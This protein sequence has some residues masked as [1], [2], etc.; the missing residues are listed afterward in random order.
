MLTLEQRGL[1]LTA[2]FAHASS[3]EL[4]EMDAATKMAYAFISAQMARDA[5]KW[6]DT[7]K[8]RQAAAKERWEKEPSQD[9]TDHA[10]NANASFAEPC[11]AND[12]TDAV[13]VNGNVDV[14]VDVI[15]TPKKKNPKKKPEPEFDTSAVIAEAVI[16][17][18]LTTGIEEW[19]AYKAERG[20]R[21]K[22]RG[23]KNL[24]VVAKDKAAQ[25]G[26]AAVV[27]RIRIDIA[28]NYQGIVWDKVGN[29][30]PRA[31]ASPTPSRKVFRA[32]EYMGGTT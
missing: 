18:A 16:S 27:E 23:L 28:A 7:R 1:L 8:K 22:E 10:N 11:N 13:Y 20:D 24:L 30:Q 26:D 4:P 21:Y 12:A 32:N 2:I 14:Y 6:E 25:F 29:G 5:Q 9:A 31:P 17:P 19:L 15:N 3:A